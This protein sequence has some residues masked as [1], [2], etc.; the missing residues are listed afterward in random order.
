MI[1]TYL[2]A[3]ASSAIALET[4]GLLQNKGERVIGISRKKAEFSYDHFYQIEKYEGNSFPAIEQ[5]LDGLVYFPGT[6]QLKPFNRFSGNDFQADWSINTLG[7]VSFVQFYLKHLNKMGN[8]SIVFISSVAATVGLTFHSSIS[9][10]KGAIEGL[11][12][13]LA[14]ELAPGIRVNAVAPSLVSTPLGEKFIN[15]PEKKQQ[16]EKRNPLGKVGEAADVAH[17]IAFLLGNESKWISGQVI[18]VDGGMSTI[19]N[20]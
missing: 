17:T 20:N 6:I 8:A 12:R 13:A 3:G 18:S 16:M 5:P 1:R 7:A 19:K 9:M 4:A 15:T 14:A 11:T 10:V 2:F